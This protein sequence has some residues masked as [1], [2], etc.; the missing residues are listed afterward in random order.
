MAYITKQETLD[1]SLE[2]AVLYLRRVY[3]RVRFQLKVSA[4]LPTQN[5]RGFEGVHFISVSR[6]QMIETVEQMG[7]VLCTDRGAK[8]RLHLTPPTREGGL[9]FV[10][11]Y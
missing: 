6:N 1:L 3:G 2:D 5:D 9:S 10:S 11:L 4:F 8:I 7:R